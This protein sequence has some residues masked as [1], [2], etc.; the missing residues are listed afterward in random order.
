MRYAAIDWL[1]NA[2]LHSMSIWVE[3]AAFTV[4]VLGAS[5]GVVSGAGLDEDLLLLAIEDFELD[6]ADVTDPVL[7]EEFAL[8]DVLIGAEGVRTDILF[9]V[10][11]F[12]TASTALMP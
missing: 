7:D 5:G 10:D 12:P 4:R 1:S 2:A 8:D 3:Y 9:S 6:A 11:A